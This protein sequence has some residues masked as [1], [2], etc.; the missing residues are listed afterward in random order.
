METLGT[1]RINTIAIRL[2][3]ITTI[4]TNTIAIVIILAI[5]II[6]AIVTIVTIRIL[7]I[8]IKWTKEILRNPLKS[9]TWTAPS[10]PH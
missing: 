6:I 8:R 5:V 10:T 7:A 9:L 2:N 3:T 1:L 4:T